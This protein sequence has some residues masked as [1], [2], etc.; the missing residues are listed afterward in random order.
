MAAP[1]ERTE[2]RTHNPS[3]DRQGAVLGKCLPRSLAVAA[4]KERMARIHPCG[5]MPRESSLPRH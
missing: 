2:P 1:S 5:E 3:R 4:R